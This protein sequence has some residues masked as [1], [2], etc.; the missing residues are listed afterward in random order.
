[1]SQADWALV[2]S[3]FSLLIALFALFWNIWS[4]FIHPKPRV[5][6]ELSHQVLVAGEVI[7]GAACVTVTNLG[8]NSVNLTSIIGHFHGKFFWKG[9][10]FH[11]KQHF[12]IPVTERIEQAVLATERSQMTLWPGTE[13]SAGQ[14][15][16]LY[17][18]KTSDLFDD[19]ADSF[20][21]GVADTFGRFHKCHPK[22]VKTAIKSIKKDHTEAL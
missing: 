6:A 19:D 5:R 10:F 8:P 16:R 1:M 17:F 15:L 20:D 18:S 22:T 7:G 11:K 14:Q 4:H 12:Y 3:A 13:L 2:I 21:I 9:R